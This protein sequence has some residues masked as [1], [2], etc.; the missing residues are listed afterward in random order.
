MPHT[1]PNP[2]PNHPAPVVDGAP[3]SPFMPSDDNGGVLN[4]QSI[5]IESGGARIKL[6]TLVLVHILS[7][8]G[9]GAGAYTWSR[10]DVELVKTQL[11]ET[12]VRMTKL[13]QSYAN[14]AD[15]L[16]RIETN[17]E[18]I[19]EQLHDRRMLNPR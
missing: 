1:T 9:V 12:Q 15:R 10:P 19:K 5:T 18:N 16:A 2:D 11:T 6:P 7:L 3:A 13:E 14:V 17:T 8:A 4:P